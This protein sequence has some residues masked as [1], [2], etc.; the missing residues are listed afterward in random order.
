MVEREDIQMTPENTYIDL[1]QMTVKE[2]LIMLNEKIREI[3]ED[4]E[5]LKGNDKC[6][7]AAIRENK[8]RVDSLET[9]V[10]IY[11]FITGVILT[12]GVGVVCKTLFF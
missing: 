9:T 4:T 7:W 1:Q 8:N 3:K 2:H 12:A 10:K 6:K 5:E 11:V